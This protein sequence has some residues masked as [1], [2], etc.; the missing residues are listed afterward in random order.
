MKIT[1]GIFANIAPLYSEPLWRELSNSE[2]IDYYFYS[3]CKGY[4]SIKTIDVCESRSLNKSGS[5]N[6]YFLKNIY[7][8]NILIYQSGVIYKCLRTKYDAYIFN[9]EMNC[10]STWVAAIVCKLRRK[11]VIFWGHGLYGNEKNIKYFFRIVFYKIADFHLIYGN[12]SRNLMLKSGFSEN[13]VFT[14]YNSL[15]FHVHE[16]FFSDVAKDD[17]IKIRKELF[18]F[19][20]DDP[21]LIF[22]GR[23]TK[24]KKVP[25]LLKALEILNTKGKRFN[26]LIIGG[27][28]EM[29]KL[30]ELK[31][32]LKIHNSICLFGENYDEKI[33]AK[34]I[35]MADCCI[36][37]GNV[38]LTAIHCLSLGTPVITHGNLENQGPEVEVIKTGI[39]G[40]FFKE[41]DINDL[42]AKIEEFVSTGKKKLIEQD[43]FDAIKKQWTPENQRAIFDKVVRL[44]IDTLG[45]EKNLSDPAQ[46]NS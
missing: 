29:L 42:S 28:P 8:K 20:F 22:L 24:E 18:P 35:M 19:S 32:S 36:S 1:C 7:I 3:S 44:S 15:N 33:N 41:D 11:P 2:T 38:G 5:F 14:V 4:S 31:D 30:R 40:Q 45:P 43:C 39:T 37:P 46:V 34:F 9:G 27:G 16:S 13:R 25:Y 10:L 26:C 6:W 12:R 21:V 23:L 17:L